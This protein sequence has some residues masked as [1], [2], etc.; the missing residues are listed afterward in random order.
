MS[1]QAGKTIRK[2]LALT[3]Y[4]DFAAVKEVRSLGA[5]KE[6]SQL[7]IDDLPLGIEPDS[8]FVKGAAVLEQSYDAGIAAKS[9][10][11]QK[12][13][14]R[15]ISVRNQETGID[16]KFRLLNGGPD[17]IGE[18][19]ETGEILVNPAGDVVLPPAEEMRINPSLVCKIEP[20]P[21]N[22]D[23]ELYYLV[24]GL[25]WEAVYNAEFYGDEFRLE[26]W[27]KI[28]NQTGANFE[29]CHLKVVAGM[30]NRVRNDF[31]ELDNISF[32]TKSFSIQPEPF[33]ISEANVFKLDGTFS[34]VEGASKQIKFLH[35]QT[36]VFQ[37]I[38]RIED[39]KENAIVQLQFGNPADFE[40]VPL[41]KG[42]I[43]FYERDEEGELHFIGEN[44]LHYMPPTEKR[45]VKIGETY[46]LTNKP[47]EKSRK[48]IGSSEYVTFEYR[49]TNSK[50]KNAAVIIEHVVSDQIWEM[51]SST[52]DYEV[53][54]S[55]TLEFHVR[56]GAGKKTEVE[57]TY[58]VKDKRDDKGRRIGAE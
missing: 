54:D 6:V 22:Q 40:E 13:V 38:Y 18:M 16:T 37:K 28:S 17:L 50:Q 23:I 2:S 45:L 51:E 46:D 57:F 5:E 9:Q 19:K 48:I 4:H 10:L 31:G 14:G 42:I 47:R 3:I 29:N 43:K 33:G 44:K 49:L 55:H 20:S 36:A 12:Y 1:I 39:R 58:K 35:S 32:S 34:L 15:E 56:I 25:K 26:G 53:I 21:L 52:H 8:F 24:A 30:V 11:L 7:I 41:P 27:V